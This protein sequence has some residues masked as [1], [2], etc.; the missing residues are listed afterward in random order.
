ME[1]LCRTKISLFTYI[2][3]I[4]LVLY[5][6]F[7]LRHKTPDTPPKNIYRRTRK[8]CNSTNS[9]STIQSEKS[10]NLSINSTIYAKELEHSIN[11][12]KCSTENLTESTNLADLPGIPSYY[13]TIMHYLFSHEN[14][15]NK[16]SQVIK[17]NTNPNK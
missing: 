3:K 5:L 10:H 15:K 4:I 12:P 6:S 1:T 8:R 14:L 17:M 7:S 2:D 16:C 13:F 9:I 11:K